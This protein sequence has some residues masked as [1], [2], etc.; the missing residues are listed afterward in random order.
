MRAGGG[1][2]WKNVGYLSR[3]RRGFDPGSCRVE[4]M[5][6]DMIRFFIFPKFKKRSPN[7]RP[8]K[9]RATAIGARHSGNCWLGATRAQDN[10]RSTRGDCPGVANN[11]IVVN[12][13][14]SGVRANA[15]EMLPAP[16]WQRSTSH[17]RRGRARPPCILPI[18][19]L[20][21]RSSKFWEEV[22]S[23]YCP[24]SGWIRPASIIPTLSRLR[25]PAAFGGF[26]DFTSS[27]A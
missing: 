7:L 17:G 20:S 26:L 11:L 19:Q 16:A 23:P 12:W 27:G 21:R 15:V 4:R 6:L 5:G 9:R 14:R 22:W 18:A 8:R 2:R 25:C 3:D 1:A 10:H 13:T 24:R